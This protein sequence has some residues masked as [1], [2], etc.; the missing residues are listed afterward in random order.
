MWKALLHGVLGA[1]PARVE[2]VIDGAGVTAEVTVRRDA[3]GVPYIDAQNDADAFYA[4]GFCQG[5]D[6]GFQLELLARAA[7]GTLAALVGAEMLPVDQLSR[8]VGFA[9]IAAAQFAA[10]DAW[11]RSLLACFARGVNDGR[12]RGPRAHEYALLLRDPEPYT[13]TDG[14]A[15]VQLFSFLLSTNWDAELARLR[16]LLADGAEALEDIDPGADASG[17]EEFPARLRDDLR[18]LADALT[19][20]RARAAPL[21]GTSAGSNAF[22]LAGARTTTGRPILACDPHLGPTLPALWYLAQARTPEWTVRGAF[23]VGQPVPS[24]GH[25]DRVAW[26]LTAGHVDNTDLFVEVVHADGARV[27][28]GDGWTACTVRE[29]RIAVRGGR[30]VTERVLETPRGPVVTPALGGEGPALSLRATWMR[31]GA[32]DWYKLVRARDVPS[33]TALFRA[34]P[35][36]SEARVFADVDGRIARKHV[37]DAPLRDGHHGTLPAPGWRVGAA[38][39]EETVPFEAMPGESDPPRGFVVTA[40][41]RPP[42]ASVWLGGDFLDPHRHDRLTEALSARDRWSVDDAVALQSDRRTTLWPSVRAAVLA[43]LANA[44]GEAAVAREMLTAWDGDVGPASAAASVYALLLAG[45]ARALV[46]DRA[47]RAGDWALGEG[48][49]GLLPR[50][51][52][53]LRRL[54]HLARCVNEQPEGFF[55]G[56]GWPAVIAAEAGRAVG[57][58]RARC[59]DDPARWSWGAARPLVLVHTL[60]AKPPLD[61]VFN[62]GPYAFG[63]DAT[64]VSQASMDFRDP[65]G[66]VIGLPNLRMVLDVGAWDDARWALAGGQSGNPFSAHYDDLAAR[67][68]RGE[69]VRL[70]WSEARVREVTVATL[71]LRPDE[72][73]R[74]RPA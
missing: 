73:A 33:A 69:T 47:P 15:V 23:L 35:G 61:G 13:A 48:I 12:G 58:L 62:L 50:G 43:A 40:N 4:L 66:P 30:D 24:F 55:V 53:P 6:R 21:A 42:G 38:W 49:N 65:F 64:T 10:Q 44:R 7:R 8:R 63:G 14:L 26:G 39:R 25:N 74:A 31:A 54:S 60:G 2:G 67:W 34:H 20:E 5:Q 27:R 32:F 68:A 29:E 22:G 1:R 51:A 41:N 46:M 72:G 28:D 36:A 71:T 3:H 56:R 45:L 16:V 52:F 9:R 57:T 17:L 70:A 19:A 37:G 59:G 11:T 18:A